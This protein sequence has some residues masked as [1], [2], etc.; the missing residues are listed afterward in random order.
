MPIIEDGKELTEYKDEV[1]H[2]GPIIDGF[3]GD[4]KTRIIKALSEMSPKVRNLIAEVSYAPTK[5]KQ[6]R[7]KIFTKDN[8]QVIGRHYNDFRQNAILSSNVT[9]IKQR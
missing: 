3:K 2:D 6:S 5:N 1:S 8:M 7:I 9:I 4:K